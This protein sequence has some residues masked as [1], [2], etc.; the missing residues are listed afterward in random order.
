MDQIVVARKLESL[1]RC[2]LRV[3]DKLPESAT[4]LAGDLDAQD[5]LVLNLSRAVQ[6][7]VDL[8]MHRLSMSSYPVPETMDQAFE[9]LAKEKIIP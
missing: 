3:H 7:C 9:T 4:A 2:L 8:A 1:R 5:V 6:L